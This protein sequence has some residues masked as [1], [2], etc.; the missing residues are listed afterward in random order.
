M[1]LHQLKPAHQ[2]KRRRRI[3]RGGKRGS[4]SGRGIKGQ[5]AR[6]GARIRPSERDMI[7]RIPKLRG[8]GN[9]ASRL[10]IAKTV[11]NLRDLATKFKEGETINKKSLLSKN[12]IRSLNEPVK[13]LGKGRLKKTLRVE[14]IEMSGSARKKAG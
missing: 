3:G 7:I 14:G 2:N 1:Q 12:L 8:F 13:I 5:K 9:S 10:K 11:L 4:Y 6:A